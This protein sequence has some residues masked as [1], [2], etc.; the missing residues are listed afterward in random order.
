MQYPSTLRS[1]CFFTATLAGAPLAFGAITYVDATHGVSANTT[2]STTSIGDPFVPLAV[3]GPANDNQ[4]DVRAFGNGTTIYQ[5]ASTPANVDNAHRLRTSATVPAGTYDVYAFFWSDASSGWRLGASLTDDQP[6][7]TLY[8]P[9]DTDVTQYY[10]VD[11]TT[12]LPSPFLS[13]SLAENPFDSA[14]MIAEGN[15]RL[16]GVYLGTTTGTS[17]D[18]FIDDDPAMADFNQRTWYD[19]IGYAVVPEPSSLALGGLGMFGLLIRRHRRS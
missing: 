3:Q 6:D 16:Y 17:I 1:I 15:R 2:G 7:L 19:G 4:W 8:Q 9:G 18:V 10:T 5:N 12:N 11:T 14:V 13:S